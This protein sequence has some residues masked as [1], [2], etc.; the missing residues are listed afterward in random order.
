LVAVPQE[1]IHEAC[2]S[3]DRG[4]AGAPGGWR[5]WFYR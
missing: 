1:L 5:T 4:G 2:I 3:H